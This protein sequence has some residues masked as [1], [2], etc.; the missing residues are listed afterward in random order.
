[1]F[2]GILALYRVNDKGQM[3]RILQSPLRMGRRF[4]KPANGNM[5]LTR[6]RDKK[7]VSIVNFDREDQTG[8]V[9]KIMAFTIRLQRYELD[10]NL[11]QGLN[12]YY[13]RVKDTFCELIEITFIG[14]CQYMMLSYWERKERIQAEF[15]E[16]S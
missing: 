12:N 8:Q 6:S 13:Q 10:D 3:R 9:F 5:T 11:N 1:M 7:L 15:Q 2:E 16:I 14:K 4:M